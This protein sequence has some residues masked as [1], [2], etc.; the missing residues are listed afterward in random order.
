[1]RHFLTR[2]P[3]TTCGVNLEKIG[4]VEVGLLIWLFDPE[5]QEEQLFD[6]YES[7]DLNCCEFI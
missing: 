2:F 7:I 6:F 3:L 5:E 4:A 1:M